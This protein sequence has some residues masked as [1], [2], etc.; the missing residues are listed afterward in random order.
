[1][2]FYKR[3]FLVLDIDKS[4]IGAGVVDSGAER[5]RRL[6]EACQPAGDRRLTRRAA[7]DPKI[8]PCRDAP[9]L[10]W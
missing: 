9:S 2:A 5:F 3:M 8:D 4:D 7:A 10:G 1:M 6:T